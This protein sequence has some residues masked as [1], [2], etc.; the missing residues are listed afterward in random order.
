[1]KMKQTLDALDRA[2]A[3]IG[4]S[5]DGK[6]NNEFTTSEFAG[7]T[8]MTISGAKDLLAREVSKGLYKS[9]SGILNGQRMNFYSLN[10]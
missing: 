7:R 2:I 6:R 10:E 3:A 4:M 5:A 8:K 1:M 9:R